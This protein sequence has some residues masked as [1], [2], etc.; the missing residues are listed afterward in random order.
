MPCVDS[1]KYSPLINSQHFQFIDFGLRCIKWP[2]EGQRHALQESKFGTVEGVPGIAHH[3]EISRGCIRTPRYPEINLSRETLILQLYWFCW[4]AKHKLPSP[5]IYI[6]HWSYYFALS[7]I[8]YRRELNLMKNVLAVKI[9]IYSKED[10]QHYLSRSCSGKIH[11]SISICESVGHIRSPSS[12][13]SEF[14]PTHLS[15]IFTRWLLS[16]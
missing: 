6:D 10:A 12:M 5:H 16:L 15:R 2:Q 1:Q 9:I 3:S 11:Q 7:V 14:S 13:V 8:P 4:P